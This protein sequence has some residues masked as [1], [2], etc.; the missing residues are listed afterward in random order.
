MRKEYCKLT[1]HL[2]R[3]KDHRDSQQNKKIKNNL[4]TVFFCSK[5]ILPKRRS[6]ISKLIGFFLIVVVVNSL[7]VYIFL[8]FL[9]QFFSSF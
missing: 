5:Q 9:K 8:N 2:E 6:S 1:T 4:S 3:I 7:M